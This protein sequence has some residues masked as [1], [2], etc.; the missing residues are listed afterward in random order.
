MPA[1]EHPLLTQAAEFIAAL[2]AF[3]AAIPEPSPRAGA[4]DDSK[5]PHLERRRPIRPLGI[6]NVPGSSDN[7][8]TI[9]QRGTVFGLE[10]GR[11]GGAW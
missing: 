5:T 4:L 2:L 8:G 11:R 7:T 10:K 6:I 9:D 3:E 1:I